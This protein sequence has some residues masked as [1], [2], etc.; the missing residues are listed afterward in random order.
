MYYIENN[1]Y[2]NSAQCT[3]RQ[4]FAIQIKSF[5]HCKFLINTIVKAVQN[6]IIINK[7]MQKNSKSRGKYIFGSKNVC[8]RYLSC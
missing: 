1:Q 4:D 6:L 7:E 2:T 3:E 5:K 8:Q